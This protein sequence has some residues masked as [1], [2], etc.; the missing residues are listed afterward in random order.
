MNVRKCGRTTKVFEC[1]SVLAQPIQYSALAPC[2]YKVIWRQRVKHGQTRW[3]LDPTSH[4]Q[5]KSFCNSGLKITRSQVRTSNPVT[6]FLEASSDKTTGRSICKFVERQMNVLNGGLHV[7]TAQR[8]KND[9]LNQSERF[10]PDDWCKLKGWARDF[11][12]LNPGSKCVLEPD[13][14][15]RYRVHHVHRVH[16]RVH[17]HVHA[18]II[19]SMPISSCPCPYLMCHARVHAHV[20][21]LIIVSMPISTVSCPCPCP[22]VHGHVPM[23]VSVPVSMPVSMQIQEDV[24]RS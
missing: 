2:P 12:R 16:A 15:N 11:E 5:H 17:A 18:H 23:P 24:R 9:V 20:H 14:D 6:E 7:R 19:V 3:K 22:H 4:L 10:Y 13:A 8:L 21:A 1:A